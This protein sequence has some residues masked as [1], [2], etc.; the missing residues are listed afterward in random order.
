[1]KPSEQWNSTVEVASHAQP[2]VKYAIRRMSFGR[3]LELM[4]HV[5][6]L[7][8]KAEYFSAGESEQSR[9]EASVLATE[10]D[11]LYVLW[12][13]EAV[14]G[15]TIDGLPATPSSLV[16]RGPE[17]LFREVLAAIRHESGLGDQER[18]N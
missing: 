11:Q 1:M 8:A 9:M 4:K 18:K 10:I 6:D 16:E 17:E 7:A 14:R 2:G 13:L 5:R 15:L 12:G 3:R